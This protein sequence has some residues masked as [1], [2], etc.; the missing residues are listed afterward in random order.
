[1]ERRAGLV[2]RFRVEMSARFV[3]LVSHGTPV[4]SISYCSR[5]FTYQVCMMGLFFNLHGRTLYPDDNQ[6][7]T[8]WSPEHGWGF[9]RFWFLV[10][11]ILYYGRVEMVQMK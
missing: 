7:S 9:R 11:S 4:A 3:T 10:G 6:V 5:G 1:M 2:P 8:F